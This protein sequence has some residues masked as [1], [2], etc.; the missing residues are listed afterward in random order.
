M[1]TTKLSMMFIIVAAIA[2]LIGGCLTTEFK[3]YHFKIN[4]D[5]SGEGTI[6]HINIVSE[7]DEG[8]NVSFADFGELTNDYL[9]GTTFEEANEHLQITDKKLYEDGGMLMGEICFTF[10]SMDSIGFYYDSSC[11]CSPFMYYAGSLAETIIESNGNYLG[12]NRDFPIILW[13]DK[14]GEFYFKTLV[15]EDMSDAHGLLPLYNA[16][17]ESK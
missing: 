14:S 1:K 10:S 8:Q 5:G 2:L 7:E 12:E 11:K 9:E 6:K 17:L 16:W 3:E 4:A 13:D 15:K